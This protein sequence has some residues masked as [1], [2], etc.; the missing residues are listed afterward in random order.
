MFIDQLQEKRSPISYYESQ[1]E[2]TSPQEVIFQ[3]G[4]VRKRISCEMGQMREGPRARLGQ[5]DMHGCRR[6]RGNCV[7]EV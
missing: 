6:R 5:C 7:W 3:W 1:R 4:T 2:D